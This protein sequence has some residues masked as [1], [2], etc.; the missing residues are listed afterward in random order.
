M[1]SI[2]LKMSRRDAVEFPRCTI[3]TSQTRPMPDPA[4]AWVGP[5]DAAAAKT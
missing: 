1:N 5:T 2:D 3:R 4:R